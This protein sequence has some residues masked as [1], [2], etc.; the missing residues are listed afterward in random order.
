MRHK[1]AKGAA[2]G[3]LPSLYAGWMAALLAGPIPQETE[4]TCSDCAMCVGRDERRT[5]GRVFF[6][7]MV[8]C[9]SFMPVL[10][11]FLV[12]RILSDAGPGAARARSSVEARIQE[13]LAVTPL[14]LDRPAK[15]DLLYEHGSAGFGQSRTLRC[16]HFVE[17]GGGRCAIWRHREA[18][19]ATYFCKHVRGSVGMDFWHSVRR[20]L[21]A[22]EAD[23]ARWCVAELEVGT[24][25][26]QSLFPS[27]DAAAGDPLGA[28]DLDN[29]PDP[30]AYER[31]WGK[32]A[33]R[34]R[35]FYARCARLVHDLSWQQVVAI[36]AP[37]VRILGR[38]TRAAYERLMSQ[39]LPPAVRAGS[40]HIIHLNAADAG[41]VAYRGEDPVQLPTTLLNVLH[42]F[43]GRP[44]REAIAAIARKENVELE[45]G[46]VRKL[47]DFQV[48]VEPGT[49]P[50]ANAGGGR[51][52]R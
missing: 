24:D 44:T 43:D 16:P 2:G 8:K 41:V 19:C 21:G 18:V 25:V 9:C 49:N 4:A 48:L 32:W 33:G 27:G 51:E 7:P 39:G 46:L 15:Y 28:A 22:V 50:P 47:A 12:G 17:P 1:I 10:P 23:L 52:V 37:T 29:R 45:D 40:L 20:L 38:V 31:L 6:D 35:S 34:E 11:N 13:R 30:A 36:C 26:L 5:A 42:Y 3:S 14:G